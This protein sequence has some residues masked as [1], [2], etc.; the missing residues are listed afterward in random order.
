MEAQPSTVPQTGTLPQTGQ[1]NWP[2]PVLVV[3][4]L[5]FFSFGWF[6]RFGRKD[7]NEK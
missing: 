7:R 6:L 4:G 2:I 1:L 5:I 3:L